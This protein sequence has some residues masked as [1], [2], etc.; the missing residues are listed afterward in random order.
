MTTTQTEAQRR[1]DKLTQQIAA[2]D[3]DIGREIDSLRKLSLEE[4]RTELERQRDLVQA[5][6]T[7][8]EKRAN[9]DLETL[10]RRVQ[11]LARVLA[12]D[13]PQEAHGIIN[14]CVVALGRLDNRVMGL[15]GRVT[16]IERQIHPP[17]RVTIWRLAAFVV[18]LFGVAVGVWQRTVF[19]VYP[20]VGVIVEAALVMVAVA[21]MLLANAKLREYRS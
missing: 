10:Q 18:L 3:K 9:G 15:E 16:A 6:L 11:D 20:V 8:H 19:G 13:H 1:Y 17:W 21:C 12:S 7:A 2:L 4:Q 14:E 5:E